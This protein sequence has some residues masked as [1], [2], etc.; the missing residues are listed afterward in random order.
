MAD[1]H[2]YPS[3]CKK[4]KN[5]LQCFL[6]YRY[7]GASLHAGNSKHM[8]AA[9]EQGYSVSTLISWA[10]MTW[11]CD[12]PQTQSNVTRAMDIAVETF[13]VIKSDYLLLGNSLVFDAS[14]AI[15]S[16]LDTDMQSFEKVHEQN[17]ITRR[18][19]YALHVTEHERP[20]IDDVIMDYRESHVKFSKVR[21][22]D[23]VFVSFC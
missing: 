22:S 21:L 4:E 10:P 7:I 14:F 18:F 23:F 15:M 16:N 8:L 6:V 19:Q 9:I 20:S 17:A 11:F 1:Q 12:A 2:G 13:N 5:N 3:F